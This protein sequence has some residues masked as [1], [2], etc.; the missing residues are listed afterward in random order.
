[1]SNTVKLSSYEINKFYLY[2]K[3]E[4]T[5][6]CFILILSVIKFY[7]II[8]EPAYKI[9]DDIGEKVKDLLIYGDLLKFLQKLKYNEKKD[10]LT[11]YKEKFLEF[12]NI[13]PKDLGVSAYFSFDKDFK[14][15]I[16]DFIKTK[17]NYE[18]EILIENNIHIPFS[19]SLIYLSEINQSDS[20][21]QKIDRMYNLRNILL[22]EIDSFWN[23]YPINHKRKYVDA[24][25]MLSLFIYLIIKSQLSNLIVD[26]EIIDDF[27][28]KNIKLSNKGRIN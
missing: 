16:K 14:T 9:V 22:D 23:G 25:N 20:L 24:D 11:K 6:I 5:Q 19:K 21:M 4:L 3:E 12:Y 15:K 28:N 7:N 2:V 27:T 1:M 8:E 26:I 18:P 17:Y 10:M 13:L